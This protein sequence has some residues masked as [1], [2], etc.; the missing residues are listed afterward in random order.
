[1]NS[2][3][4][5]MVILLVAVAVVAAAGGTACRKSEAPVE[6]TG[7]EKFRIISE[8]KNDPGS[9]FYID[10]K[11]YPAVRNDLPIGV[12]D[13]GTGGLTVLDAILKMDEFDN[14]THEPG[15]DGLPDFVEERF[16]YL[17]DKANMPYGRYDSEGKS[18]FLREL[19]IKDIQFLL[20]SGYYGAAEDPEPR[21]DKPPVKAVVIACNTATAYG[22]ELAREAFLEWGLD[23]AV[24]GIVDSGAKAALSRLGEGGEPRLVGVF[25]TEGTCASQGYPQAVERILSGRGTAGVD[26]IQ[27]AGFG[28]AGAVDGDPAYIDSGAREVRGPDAY[29]GPR[30][31]H[32]R[33]PIDPGRLEEYNFDRGGNS[34]LVREDAGGRLIE[35]ELNSVSN[36]IRFYVTRMVLESASLFPG[37]SLDAVILGCTHYPYF[38]QE[39]QEHFNYLRGLD[40][41]YASIIPP[42]LPV[43]DPAVS[44]AKE[45]YEYLK[46]EA[47]F[48]SGSFWDSRFF[49]SVPNPLLKQN[50]IEKNGEFSIDY[51]YGRTINRSLLEVKQVPL[52]QK[53][54]APDVF[55]RIREKMP[56]I[57]QI[58]GFE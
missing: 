20:G 58:M 23:I 17:G 24:I 36:Y 57:F 22:L 7:I 48:G 44:E 8:I 49:I 37:R 32:P 12:F 33:Y 51:K 41:A 5:S 31:G 28:W 29:Q 16:I 1:M 10:F 14:Q 39:I 11:H 46:R 25:A 42:N 15:G 18:D 3:K 45:L 54:L 56:L 26:V 52:T 55:S 30:L 19:V 6:L 38:K 2:D 21:R 40:P 34:L 47:L 13:S 43:I 9:S 27:Q 4:R 35:I 50:R 53:E